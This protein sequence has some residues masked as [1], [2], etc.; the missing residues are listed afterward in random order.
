MLDCAVSKGTATIDQAA[1]FD[2]ALPDSQKLESADFTV[3]RS[4][5][6][7]KAETNEWHCAKKGVCVG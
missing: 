7:K 2:L 1:E 6:V 5:D 3:D 4:S